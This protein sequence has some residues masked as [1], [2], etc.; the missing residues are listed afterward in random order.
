MT[1][2]FCF[3]VDL[4]VYLYG[5]GIYFSNN[6]GK[7]W[8][9]LQFT[10]NLTC[11]RSVFNPAINNGLFY[12]TCNEGLFVYD[13]LKL[14]WNNISP[15]NTTNGY[16]GIDVSRDGTVI[17]IAEKSISNTH[18]FYSNINLNNFKYE[19]IQIQDAKYFKN[20]VPWYP[21]NWFANAISDIKC[22]NQFDKCKRIFFSDWYQIWFND[23]IY[24]INNMTWYTLENGHE[25]I[26]GLAMTCPTKG[27]PLISGTADCTGFRH[28]NVEQYPTFKYNGSQSV[29]GIDFCERNPDIIVRV[30]GGEPYDLNTTGWISIDNGLT[31][32]IFPN[33]P[34]INN[35]GYF[36]GKILI[37][38][39][40]CNHWVWIPL[41]SVPYITKDSGKTW[42]KSNISAPLNA[43][44]MIS[45]WQNNPEWVN[46][47]YIHF[48][49]DR[50]NGNNWYILC[51]NTIY[52]SND[53]GYNWLFIYNNLP[54]PTNGYEGGYIATD[55]SKQDY[56]CV[57]LGIGGMY[58]GSIINSKNMYKIQDIWICRMVTF[59][60]KNENNIN[61]SVLYFFGLTHEDD[62]MNEGMY[63]M[64][65]NNEFIRMN[66]NSYQLG[67]NTRLL[68]ADRQTFGRVYLGSNG[69]GIYYSTHI[70]S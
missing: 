2:S 69:R 7:N 38:P 37:N 1:A 27:A 46:A 18:I 13:S 39:Q 31:W 3:V 34:S 61:E 30:A 17:V 26:F 49:N 35:N 57:C 70:V 25:E 51:N 42:I 23:N 54:Y 62:E 68:V 8:N 21:N 15:M 55:F 64:I 29:M 19:W 43:G 36:G 47:Y 59:G 4:Y 45:G 53:G 24:N 58:C 48:A 52:G 14:K 65:N 11:Y 33:A 63:I 40:D 67:D 12:I 66:N 22:D 41:S 60:I 20:S 9:L 28:E 16:Q 6:N 50:I 44:G 56:L 5:Y 32:N 10:T